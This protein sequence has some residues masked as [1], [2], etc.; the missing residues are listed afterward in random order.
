VHHQPSASRSSGTRVT[1]RF[2]ADSMAVATALMHVARVAPLLPPSLAK[3]V[4]NDSLISVRVRDTVGHTLFSFGPRLPG[5]FLASDTLLDGP[6]VAPSEE[7]RYI[8]I[9]R[10]EATRLGYL[11]DRVLR[12]SARERRALGTSSLTTRVSLPVADVLE[13]AI[14]AFRP[15]AAQAGSTIT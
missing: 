13:E 14:S 3:G 15:L 5:R 9:I 8:G 12:F 4:P 10:R 7:R 1:L 6:R 11:V 2:P